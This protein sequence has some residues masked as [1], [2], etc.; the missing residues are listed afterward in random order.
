MRGLCILKKEYCRFAHGI[1]DIID[2]SEEEMEQVMQ[3]NVREGTQKNVRFTNDS[4]FNQKGLF[5]H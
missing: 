1:D 5:A 3:I 2:Y 4:Y